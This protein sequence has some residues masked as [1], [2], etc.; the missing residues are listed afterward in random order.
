MEKKEIVKYFM[1]MVN[2]D[3]RHDWGFVKWNFDY[4]F[5]FEITKEDWEEWRKEIL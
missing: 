2:P 3:F 5:K 4:Y 1:K